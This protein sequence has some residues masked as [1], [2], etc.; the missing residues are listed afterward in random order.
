MSKQWNECWFMINKDSYDQ[1][2]FLNLIN[3]CLF[4][5]LICLSFLFCFL[6]KPWNLLSRDIFQLFEKNCCFLQVQGFDKATVS[7]VI[8][9][10]GFRHCI[11]TIYKHE[12]IA[13]L[14]KGLAA[15]ILKSGATS[16]LIFFTY[17][18]F[19]ELL[20]NRWYLEVNRFFLWTNNSIF[21]Y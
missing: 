6:F 9:Y 18:F 1:F 3:L 20:R 12:G 19:S 2:G 10:K 13:G 17:E 4:S 8:K 7:Q 5:L 11:R 14:Y 15:S 16:G 21:L